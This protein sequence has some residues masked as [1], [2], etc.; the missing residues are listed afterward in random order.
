MSKISLNDVRTLNS[1]LV[2]DRPLVAVFFGGTG[3]ISRATLRELAK[4]EAKTGRSLRAYIIARNVKAGDDLLQ[5]CR[6][7]HPDGQFRF[8]K[9]ENLSLLQDIDRICAVLTQ[10]EEKAGGTDARIDYLMM[11]QGGS[12]FNPRI[13]KSHLQLQTHVMG[14]LTE[15]ESDTP[16][17]IDQ[18]MSLL[19]YS[20][21]K[22]IINLLPLLIKSNLPASIVSVYA[23]GWE[24][25]FF[26]DDLSLRQPTRFTY[27][28]A[29]SHMV[30]MY[31]LCFEALAAQHAGKLRLAHVFPGLV[32]GPA[33]QNPEL[34]AWFRLT[35]R[36]LGPIFGPL[37]SVPPEECGERSKQF[38]GA[39]YCPFGMV[40]EDKD[41]RLRPRPEIRPFSNPVSKKR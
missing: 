32:L 10:M 30:H 29:R 13:G 7:I 21:M 24:A 16:E 36:V 3:G 25:K 11:S 14:M 18:A 37:V 23:A 5:E 15:A 17:G 4:A 35:M 39:F 28:L 9:A 6:E 20:R 27:P 40:V 33:F 19:Y 26:P 8:I 1:A 12:F 2:R 31:T 38:Q 41:E 34:P 22:A